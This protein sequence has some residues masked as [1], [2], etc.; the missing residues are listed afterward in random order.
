VWFGGK[1]HYVGQKN[2][3]IDHKWQSG[4]PKS[5]LI[6]ILHDLGVDN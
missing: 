1:A 5:I 4:A 3:R 2:K 6:G